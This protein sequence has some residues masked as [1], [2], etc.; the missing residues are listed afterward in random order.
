MATMSEFCTIVNEYKWTLKEF[1][2]LVKTME[3]TKS[4]RS[5]KFEIQV[6]G[7]DGQP[8][9]T[10]WYLKCYPAGETKETSGNISLFLHSQSSPKLKVESLRAYME[11]NSRNKYSLF[12]EDFALGTGRGFSKYISHR[13]LFDNPQKYLS[14]YKDLVIQFRIKILPAGAS[15]LP[16]RSLA[17]PSLA[18]AFAT[19]RDRQGGRT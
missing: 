1:P 16:V 10:Q 6:T 18:A 15:S 8:V 3:N 2:I 14:N 5:T 13:N 17:R 11:F 4:M 12:T 7:S 9:T 19:T